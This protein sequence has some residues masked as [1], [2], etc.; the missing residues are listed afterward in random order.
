M[1]FRGGVEAAG[2]TAPVPELETLYPEATMFGTLPASVFYL[3]HLEHVHI[4]DV[5]V[6]FTEADGRDHLVIDDV[7]GLSHEG[8]RIATGEELGVT[9]NRGTNE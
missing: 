8:I 1:Q 3:R 6:E 9:E 5:N 4:S 7:Q 2:T